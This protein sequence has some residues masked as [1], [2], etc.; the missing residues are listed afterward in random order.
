VLETKI[1]ELR[2]AL[3]L[4]GVDHSSIPAYKW[5]KGQSVVMKALWTVE[6]IALD[7]LLQDHV[8]KEAAKPVNQD[9]EDEEEH[10]VSEDEEIVEDDFLNEDE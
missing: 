5:I 7:K 2:A 1:A 8:E 4:R 10:L 9:K 3:Q 6:L